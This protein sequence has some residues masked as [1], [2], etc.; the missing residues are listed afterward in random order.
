LNHLSTLTS[1][2]QSAQRGF[3]LIELVITVALVAIL[4]TLAFPDMSETLRQWRRDSATR[5]L[6]SD[7]ELAR[8]HSIKTSRRVSMCTSTNGT[9]C[10]ASNDWRNGWILFEDDGATDLVLDGVEVPFKVVGAQAGILTLLSTNNVRI[11]QFLPNGLMSVGNTTF[12][13]TPT[14]ATAATLLNRVALSRVGRASVTT[15][16]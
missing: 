7:L 14:G 16:P 11:V 8:T 1:S 5:A 3:T 13:V 9:T 2:S 15:G 4:A 6:T 10:A 12:T